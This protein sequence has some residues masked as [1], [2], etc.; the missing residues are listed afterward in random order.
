MKFTTITI[1]G[2]NKN[3]FFS[4]CSLEYVVLICLK[5][6]KIRQHIHIGHIPKIRIAFLKLLL[7]LN[8]ISQSKFEYKNQVKNL[9]LLSNYKNG[10][11]ISSAPI[12]GALTILQCWKYKLP[13]LIYNPK[14]FY[15]NFYTFLKD[16]LLLW[17]SV[18]ELFNK[19]ENLT[20]YYEKFSEK[21]YKH[22]LFLKDRK[23][24]SKKFLLENTNKKYNLNLKEE[25][26]YAK[27]N[28]LKIIYTIFSKSLYLI[29]K[30][31][32]IMIFVYFI[33]IQK[34]INRKIKMANSI[35]FIKPFKR[36]FRLLYKSYISK[37]LEKY[38]K[39]FLIKFIN[40]I[41]PNIVVNYQINSKEK[42]NYK[43]FELFK[44]SKSTI[45]APNFSSEIIEERTFN[46][47]NA[48]L[49]NNV[50]A[51]TSSSSFIVKDKIFVDPLV[52]MKFYKYGI[53]TN[54]F[55]FRS[56]PFLDD[57]YSPEKKCFNSIKMLN[58]KIRKNQ[59]FNIDKG[60]LI[61][62][63]GSSNWY[64]W[65]IECLP[66]LFILKNLPDRFLDYPLLVPEVCRKN[67]NFNESL[68]IF[69]K[70][71]RN[72]FYFKDFSN[73]LIRNL[74]YIDDVVSSPFQVKEGKNVSRKDYGQNDSLLKNYQDEFHDFY[75]I[76]YKHHETKFSIQGCKRIFL[77]RKNIYRKYNQEQLINISYKY[78]FKS[79]FL[80]DLSLLEQ[81]NLML[82]AKFV[83]GPS[84]AAWTSL[85]FAKN[86]KLKCLSWLPSSLSEA[87]NY[88]NL[89]NLFNH[90]M[91]FLRINESNKNHNFHLD[92]YTIDPILFEEKLQ[93][94]ITQ[95]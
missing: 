9:E 89:A 48:Y 50:L 58:I 84:G 28:I 57:I 92:S 52:Y 26:I 32:M 47:I 68:K 54:G 83:V 31:I 36:K 55:L 87:C 15:I 42:I 95:S 4:K 64:H 65:I 81:I 62:G 46:N 76:N 16:D 1:G 13:V 69:N 22:Y 37:F 61:G 56:Y 75:K 82:E 43:C 19:L 29:I 7:T 14:I 24:A 11:V 2:G 6:R 45:S 10:I 35:N 21:Y 17:N 74:I 41:F 85:L 40:L 93:K 94:L 8:N 33:P 51:S 79:V 49:I 77:A 70:G 44:D 67:N 86:R 12:V 18:S 59:I 39:E 78:G 5:N 91:I 38:I 30:I 20:S 63:D 88:S 3:F 53:S 23:K 73:I 66:K 90:E 27:A 25:T 80:E 71:K 72:I 60:I 34:K